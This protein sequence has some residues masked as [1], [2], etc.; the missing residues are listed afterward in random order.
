MWRRKV[1]ENIDLDN[2][3]SQGYS[4]NIELKYLAYKNGFSFIEIPIIFEER[5]GGVSKISKRIILEA[6]WKVLLLRL[7]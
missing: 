5:R 6:V 3:K 7:T 4:C 1:L 2:I